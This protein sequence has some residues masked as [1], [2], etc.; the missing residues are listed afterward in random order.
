MRVIIAGSRYISEDIALRKVQAILGI[1]Y[2]ATKDVHLFLKADSECKRITKLVSGCAN[3][4]DQVSFLLEEELY[5][6]GLI[7]SFTVD[8]FHANWADHG[9]SAGPR[10]NKLMAQNADLLILVW[11]GKSKGSKNMKEEMEKLGKPVVE[12]IL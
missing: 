6:E 11:N 8:E 12:I 1:E 7:P 10:R 3:G 9:R 5:E 2:T 4:P